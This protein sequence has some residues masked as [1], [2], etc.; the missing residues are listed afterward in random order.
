MCS[1]LL[2]ANLD[3][4]SQALH[5]PL[6]SVRFAGWLVSVSADGGS[7]LGCVLVLN[8]ALCYLD[9]SS[10]SLSCFLASCSAANPHIAMSLLNWNGRAIG[11][12][13]KLILS[14]RESW[15]PGLK[16]FPGR[17][18]SRALQ[19]DWLEYLI[20]LLWVVSWNDTVL[21]TLGWIR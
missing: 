1:E 3:A 17:L 20:V 14:R 4:V 12:P 7:V 19:L 15:Q 9:S 18:S 21:G 8:S 6:L 11:I 5:F 16:A 13:L 10:P 2:G